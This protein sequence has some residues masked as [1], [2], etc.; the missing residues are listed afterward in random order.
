MGRKATNPESD[1]TNM[2]RARQIHQRLF[3]CRR[4]PALFRQ[5]CYAPRS[6]TYYGYGGTLKA[7]ER[8]KMALFRR[9]IYIPQPFSILLK[10]I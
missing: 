1:Q 5:F 9:F 8:E 3:E 6:L 2:G 7:Y 10:I 4:S